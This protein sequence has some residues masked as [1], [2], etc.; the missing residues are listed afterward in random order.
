MISANC[1]QTLPLH[2]PYFMQ[3]NHLTGMMFVH[4][5]LNPTLDSNAIIVQLNFHP[6][7]VMEGGHF[8]LIRID[9]FSSTCLIPGQ[10]YTTYQV[11]LF[12]F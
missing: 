1:S 9:F 2:V 10:W 6:I 7:L 3:G 8:A 11:N 5:K 4:L 12:I